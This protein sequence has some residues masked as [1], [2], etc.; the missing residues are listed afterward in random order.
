MPGLPFLSIFAAFALS[1]AWLVFYLREDTHPEPKRLLLA[2]FLGGMATAPVAILLECGWLTFLGG[3]CGE[4][5]GTPTFLAFLGY[6][7]I[8]ETLKFLVVAIGV[9]RSKEFDEPVDAMIY[10]I[11]SALGF[12][13]VE[14]MFFLWRPFTESVGFGIQVAGLRFVGATLLHVLVSA[15]VGYFFALAIIMRERAYALIAFGLGLAT[16][17]H[18]LFNSLILLNSRTSLVFLGLLLV[19]LILVVAAYFTKL[20]RVAN[21]TNA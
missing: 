5:S 3:A 12:A 19:A 13:A 1:V 16:I 17:L 14:N 11:V 8:E 2:V 4:S 20:R 21:R 18:A 7:F 10:L 9:S 15:V 6:A